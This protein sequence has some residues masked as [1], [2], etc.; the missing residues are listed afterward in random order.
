MVRKSSLAAALV[1]VLGIG[2]CSETG[3][4]GGGARGGIKTPTTTAGAGGGSGTPTDMSFGQ[5]PGVAQ[6]LTGDS[7]VPIYT[8]PTVDMNAGPY[9]QDDTGGSGLDQG[10]I[11]AL[12]AGGGTCATDVVYPYNDTMFPGA[13]APPIIMWQGGADAAYVRFAYSQSDKVNYEY[14][15]GGTSPG[16]LQIPRDAWNEI[17]RRTNNLPLVVTLSVMNGGSVSTCE[18]QWRIAPGNMTGAIYYNTYQAPPP[19]VEGQG[20]VMRVTLG[21]T[22]EIYKQYTG[23][24]LG[25]LGPCY[26]CHSVSFDGSTMVASFHDYT[27]KIF[28]VEK[29]DVTQN[30]QPTASGMIHNANFGALTPDGSRILAMGNPECT[31]NAETFPR[32]PNNFPLVEGA[33]VARVLDTSNGN[34]TGAVGL[35]NENYMWMAQFSPDGDKVV[36]NHAKPDG[37]GGTD[38]RELAVMDYDYTTNTFSNL[39]VVV[40]ADALGA[41]QGTNLY[42]PGPAG[43][44]LVPQGYEG[45]TAPDDALDPVRQVGGI[46]GGSCSGPCYPAW[47]FFTPDGKAVIFSMISDPDFAQAFPGRDVPSKSELW[48]VDIET[49]EIV[50][51][52]RANTGRQPLDLT[53]NH[54]PT[55]MP[56]AV[57]GYFWVFW[58]AVRDYGHK[59]AGQDPNALPNAYLDAVKKRIWVA[60]I[61]PRIP[62]GGEIVAEPAPLTDPS[63]PGF[64]LDGQSASGNVRAFAALNPCLP[65]LAE[66]ASGLDC[67]CGFCTVLDGAPKGQCC[68]EIP[69]CAKT[70]EKCE[71]DADCCP[72]ESP[73]EPQNKCLGGFCGFI[74]LE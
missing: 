1:C 58:T 16:E 51:L 13:L 52:D 21:S 46:P 29:Y 28:E 6:M 63:F 72:P 57:G 35:T 41:P 27:A 40:S 3:D 18:L 23:L 15:T 66:C 25:P 65:D 71:T 54:Y 24:V 30:T 70:N 60:A 33:A 48:Y 42:Q 8:P 67:C 12:K 59:V 55:V 53:A 43:A 49:Q 73:D 69:E 62:Q 9:V 22:F 36:F 47:P 68:L 44:G 34:D 17:T 39:R 20:A 2:G 50:R 10:T 56:V 32:K 11:D 64:Y 38:R 74:A 14:A 5:K 19:G 26:S 45:C 61:K 31:Q 37:V 7:G 4:A